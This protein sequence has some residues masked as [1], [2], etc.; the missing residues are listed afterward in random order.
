[1]VCF[2]GYVV[3]L[4]T[5][6]VGV[7]YCGVWSLCCLCVIY[8]V[9][10]LICYCSSLVGFCWCLLLCFLLIACLIIRFG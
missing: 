10:F 1:M 5:T 2:V 8:F 3:N 7:V 6:C 4:N 9:C